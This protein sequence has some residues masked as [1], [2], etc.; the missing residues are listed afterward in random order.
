MN[1]EYWF[2]N[3]ELLGIT[4]LIIVL[5]SK[6]VGFHSHSHLNL[7][8][9]IFMANVLT[10]FATVAFLRQ[11]TISQKRCWKR[12]LWK[13]LSLL[14]LTESKRILSQVTSPIFSLPRL[15]CS[16][17]AKRLTDTPISECPC[18]LMGK[19]SVSYIAVE[20][21]RLRVQSQS[22]VLVRFFEVKSTYPI[23][24]RIFLSFRLT[25]HQ[26]QISRKSDFHSALQ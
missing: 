5:V 6:L 8:P 11:L 2:G 4:N 17:C 9:S 20:S 19:A 22:E 18:G 23:A 15:K 26:I 1:L 14:Q 25:K 24:T 12:E 3:M 7:S 16:I 21:R 10:N 13:T